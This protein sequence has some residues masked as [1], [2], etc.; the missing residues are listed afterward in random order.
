MLPKNPV[1]SLLTITFYTLFLGR[2]WQV[3]PRP[4][5]DDS[6]T[7]EKY[8]VGKSGRGK[9]QDYGSIASLINNEVS[10]SHTEWWS[11]LI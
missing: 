1:I 7:S 6:V 2:V 8:E 3:M 4:R 9:D 11:L 10:Q 5:F